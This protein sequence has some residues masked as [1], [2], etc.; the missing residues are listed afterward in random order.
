MLRKRRAVNRN[1][2]KVLDRIRTLHCSYNQSSFVLLFQEGRD[3]WYQGMVME[4]DTNGIPDV[5]DRE[6]NVVGAAAAESIK[7][8]G[9]N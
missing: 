1:R 5:Q 6:T 3:G 7:S 9:L 4:Y 2:V 8:M